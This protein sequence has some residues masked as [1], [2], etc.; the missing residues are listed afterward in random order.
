MNIVPNKEESFIDSNTRKVNRNTGI[1]NNKTNTKDELFY[2][3]ELDNLCSK[4]I[5]I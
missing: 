3:E 1:N 2:E 5:I 4:L